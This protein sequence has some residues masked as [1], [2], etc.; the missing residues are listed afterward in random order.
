MGPAREIG[1]FALA[2]G[3]KRAYGLL[4]EIGNY[5]FWTFDLEQHRVLKRT[6]FPGRP[7]ME[8]AVSSNGKLLYVSGAGDTIDLY[9]AATH[10]FLR[11]VTLDAEIAALYVL[12]KTPLT[13]SQPSS[14]ASPS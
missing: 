8:L 13:L 4:E 12:P 3:R 10:R 9:D 6:P 11:T 14:V 2:P 1:V 7:R 5:E